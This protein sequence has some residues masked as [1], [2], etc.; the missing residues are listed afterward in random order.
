MQNLSNCL[1][2]NVLR[3]FLIICA[4][5]I[6]TI[7]TIFFMNKF[8]LVPKK[9][10]Q[11]KDFDIK[12]VYS[13]VDFDDD[14]IDDY[15][16]FLLG[17]RKDA[18]NHPTYVSK[19]YADSYPPDSEGVCTDVIWRAFKNA[20]YSLR[21]MVYNDIKNNKTANVEA[22]KIV[23]EDGT[24]YEYSKPERAIFRNS[25]R[26]TSNVTALEFN[27]SEYESTEKTTKNII[28]VGISIGENFYQSIEYVLKYW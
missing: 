13:S 5:L 3:N 23:F 10:Y 4:I 28:T 15:S 2:K 12:T 14:D 25:T 22:N 8:N 21:D 20:G 6:F 27:L 19:Y 17:A 1:K 16:D 26:I 11:A 24:V 18:E 9:Y 7:V